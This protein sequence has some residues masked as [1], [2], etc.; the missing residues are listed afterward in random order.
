LKK[1]ITIAAA[2][3]VA[4]ILFFGSA[5]YLLF[6]QVTVQGYT[7]SI[8]VYTQ[9]GGKG[10]GKPG[11]NF[12]LSENETVLT[13]NLYI[14]VR[15][16]SNIPQAGRLVAYEVRRPEGSTNSSTYDLGSPFTNTSGIAEVTIR[17]YSIPESI[18][19]WLVYTTVKMD[20]QILVDALTFEI[21]P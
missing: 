19:K 11:G 8:D 21:T 1:E 9:R 12:S 6:P 2:S 16:A 10:T 4:L 17:I 20:D 5:S 14:E 3:A 15:N 7:A 18:G 13:V